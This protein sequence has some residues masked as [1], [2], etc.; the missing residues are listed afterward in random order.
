MSGLSGRL[1]A[2]LRLYAASDDRIDE[3]RL[4]DQFRKDLAL[5]VAEYG[6]KTVYAALD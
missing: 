3:T 1:E 4:A 5:L 6:P 2:P